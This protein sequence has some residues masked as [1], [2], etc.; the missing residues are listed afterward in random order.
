MVNQGSLF[1]QTMIGWSPKSYIPSFCSIQATANREKDFLRVFTIYEH[2]G[3]FG[4]VTSAI[5]INF[6]FLV[7]ESLQTIFGSK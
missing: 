6:H 2:G 5:V 3:H 7:P 4:H 1:V